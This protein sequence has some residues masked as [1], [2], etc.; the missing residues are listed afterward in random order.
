[1]TPAP[2]SA[3]TPATAR[4]TTA[5][6]ALC[7]DAAG[8]LGPEA[9]RHWCRG[10]LRGCLAAA[11]SSRRPGQRAAWTAAAAVYAAESGQGGL[12]EALSQDATVSGCDTSASG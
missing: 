8:R 7:L 5:A 12:A 4:E 1:M 6:L 10:H 11:R 2:A 9:Y 3:P